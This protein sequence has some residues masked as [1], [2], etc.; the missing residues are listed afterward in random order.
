MNET[1]RKP[2]ARTRCPTL[3]D[4]WHW[5]LYMS[6]RTDRLDIPRPLFTQ[7][8]RHG[9]TYQGLYLPSH[10][11]TTGHTKA[12]IYPVTQTRLDI[13]R[14]LF[15]QSHRHGWTYQG[16]Y[17]PSHT[18]TAGHT[19]AFIYPVTQTRLGIPRPLFTQSHRHGWTYQ[20]LYL[21]S[22][23]DRLDIPRPLFT[24]SWTTWGKLYPGP[25]GGGDL[26]P[27]GSDTYTPSPSLV[28]FER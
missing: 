27:I 25:Q 3:F 26:L 12:F 10:T 9:W 6:S 14:P 5:I 21:P 24:Q 11:D 4:K 2:T 16:L 19:K 18:D 17:L 7:P 1:R 20:G 22:R 13:P 28:G 15:T 8:H 23:T